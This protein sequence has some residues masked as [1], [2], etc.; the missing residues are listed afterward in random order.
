MEKYCVPNYEDAHEFL[1][2]LGKRLGKLRKGKNVKLV[3]NKAAFWTN[4]AYPY[5]PPYLF[6]YFHCRCIRRKMPVPRSI[7]MY[8]V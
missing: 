7:I 6:Q 1:R 4:L 8:D 3:S 5:K 2:H